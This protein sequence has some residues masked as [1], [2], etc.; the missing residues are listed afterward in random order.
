MSRSLKKSSKDWGL[1][2]QSLRRVSLYG[3]PTLPFSVRD[4]PLPYKLLSI[5]SKA[6]FTPPPQS[7]KFN[8]NT[9]S[10]VSCPSI[11][12]S[13]S[14]ILLLVYHFGPGIAKGH[15]SIE[16]QFARR[17]ISGVNTEIAKPFKLI[18]TAWRCVCQGRLNLARGECF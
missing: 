8:L 3:L 9:F 1:V 17:R 6:F 11:D 13:Q 14:T 2:S 5:R 4:K 7:S 12:K 18:S 15:N 10:E 16:Y